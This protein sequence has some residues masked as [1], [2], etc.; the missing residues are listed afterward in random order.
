MKKYILG[1]CLIA[2]LLVLSACGSKN[3]DVNT[4]STSENSKPVDSSTLDKESII[5]TWQATSVERNGKEVSGFERGTLIF[6]DDGTYSDNSKYSSSN[7]LISSG[8]Y[9]VNGN[10]ISMTVAESSYA[11]LG[12]SPEADISIKG[13]ILTL[14][15]A[16]GVVGKYKR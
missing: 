13:N 10:K 4:P 1:L 15:Y 2:I 16:N 3:V 14:S 6:K 9:E 7:E 11:T 5:G 12:T 8:T